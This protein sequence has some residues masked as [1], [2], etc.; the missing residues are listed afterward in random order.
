MNLNRRNLGCA[1]H[2]GCFMPFWFVFS[3]LRDL[4]VLVFWFFHLKFMIIVSSVHQLNDFWTSL[5]F[6]QEGSSHDRGLY[7]RS[8]RGTI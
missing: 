3:T 5:T 1:F 6:F 7:A 4:P 2:S 8:I